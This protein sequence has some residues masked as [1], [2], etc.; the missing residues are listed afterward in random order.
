MQLTADFKLKAINWADGFEYC[1]ILD[2]NSYQDPYGKYDFMIAAGARAVVQSKAEHAFETLKNF[3]DLSPDWVFGILGYDL[4]NGL[5]NLQSNNPDHLN[6]P[7]MSFFK[8]E[9]LIISEQGILRV[10]IGNPELLQFLADFPDSKACPSNRPNLSIQARM[11][12]HSYLKKVANLK[13][14]ILRGDIYEVTFCQEFFAEQVDIN[15]AETFLQLNSN[16]PTPFAAYLKLKDKYVICAS[17]ER[18]LS[19]KA[20]QLISQP[21]KGT[22]A[23]GL[24]ETE[25]LKI[26]MQLRNDLKEQTENVM[27]VDL[28]RNDLTKSA[29]PASVKVEEQFGIYSFPQVHQM[30]STVSCMLQE[31]IH[32]ID[33][34][35]NTFPM[36]S[37]T[38]APKVR[39][40][41]LIEQEE[42]SK[43]GAYSGAIGYIN[44]DADFDFNVV[45]RSILYAKDTK[46]LSFQV[47]GAITHDSV[48][49]KEY[50]ECLLKASAIVKTLKGP[51]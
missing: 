39:A 16:A 11:D 9:H 14:H 47:G 35:K 20:Q 19:K 42:L 28:V 13:Q 4:K 30:I 33:A 37:M 48:P 27:I 46:D 40:M 10:E 44:P 29:V 31:S 22:T 45:I 24:N 50:Q 23:R 6:F 18:F 34:I 5:E 3:Y 26:K 7:E 8:P 38:G 36:G 1:C 17:P 12:K 43:R 25:D 21:I 41:E 32:V 51:Q 49:E 2:S 15:P